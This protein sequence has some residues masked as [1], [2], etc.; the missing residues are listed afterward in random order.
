MIERE[1]AIAVRAPFVY[2]ST[3]VSSSRPMS[4]SPS[5]W[6]KQFPDSSIF[7]TIWVNDQSSCA[8]ECRGHLPQLRRRQGV[9]QQPGELRTIDQL[10]GGLPTFAARLADDKV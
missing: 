4:R 9:H 2:R 10:R 7:R 3:T 8:K 5:C 1:S 6:S